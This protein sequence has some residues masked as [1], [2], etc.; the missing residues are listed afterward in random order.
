MWWVAVSGLRGWHCSS[1]SYSDGLESGHQLPLDNISRLPWYY[2]SHAPLMRLR[3]LPAMALIKVRS[4]PATL[5]VEK[6]LVSHNFP[7]NLEGSFGGWCQSL[8][9]KTLV[10]APW[11]LCAHS[12]PIYFFFHSGPSIG[13][14]VWCSRQGV[15]DFW[16][17]IVPPLHIAVWP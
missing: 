1:L 17:Q 10:G 12:L 15:R 3:V 8:V 5:P 7:E 6:N 11:S 14:V 13:I 4:E 2:L 9:T 16:I